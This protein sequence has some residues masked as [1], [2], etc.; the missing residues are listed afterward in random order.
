MPESLLGYG[1]RQRSVADDLTRRWVGSIGLTA[2]VGSVYFL[3]GLLGIRLLMPPESVAVF[4]PA[5]GISSGVLIALGPGARWP[6][7]AGTMVATIAANLLSKVDIWTTCAFVL[8]N[9]AEPLIIAG[10][11]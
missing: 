4:W 8:G 9:T 2:A 7:A 6:V 10:I 1:Q 11:D 5:A 3:A